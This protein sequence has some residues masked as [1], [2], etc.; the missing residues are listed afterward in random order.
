MEFYDS[1]K[2]KG[3]TITLATIDDMFPGKFLGIVN[4]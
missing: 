2:Q 3:E 1:A 4:D